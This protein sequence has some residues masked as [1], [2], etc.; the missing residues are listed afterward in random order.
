MGYDNH[1]I[2]LWDLATQQVRAT[3]LQT[4]G[5]V[6]AL[7][8]SANGRDM[9]CNDGE[10]IRIWDIVSQ[11]EEL[12]LGTQRYAFMLASQPPLYVPPQGLPSL[13]SRQREGVPLSLEILRNGTPLRIEA[14]LPPGGPLQLVATREGQQLSLQVN[15]DPVLH[16]HDAMAVDVRFPGVL[17][18]DWPYEVRLKRLK[19]SIKTGAEVSIPLEQGDQLLAEG[20][21]DLA[22]QQFESQIQQSMVSADTPAIHLEAR[23]KAALCLQKLNRI[24]Q[25]IEQFQAV[26]N[27][28]LSNREDPAQRSWQLLAAA[29]LW[30]LYV[31]QDQ[32][33]PAATFLNE[34]RSR[35]RLPEI[36]RSSL[37]TRQQLFDAYVHAGKSAKL[38][39]DTIGH[40]SMAIEV[41]KLFGAAEVSLREVKLHLASAYYDARMLNEAELAATELL[42]EIEFDSPGTLASQTL[43]AAFPVLLLKGRIL[44]AQRNFSAAQQLL[45]HWLYSTPGVIREG[46]ARLKYQLLLECARLAMA[47]DQPASAEPYLT[48][49]AQRNQDNQLPYQVHATHCLLSGLVAHAQEPQ[50]AA[51][52]AWF[53]RGTYDHWRE[54]VPES[55]EI[56]GSRRDGAI[57]NLALVS[58]CDEVSEEELD[59]LLK[60]VEVVG[61]QN[62]LGKV[63]FSSQM[64]NAERLK[65][66]LRTM[67]RS[68]RG[69]EMATQVALGLGPQQS[70]R[71]IYLVTATEAMHQSASISVE[72][73]ADAEIVWLAS[74]RLI[75]AYQSGEV[76][77]THAVRLAATWK[78]RVEF[79]GWKSVATDL[80]PPLRGPLAYV[81]GHRFSNVLGQPLQ[82]AEFFKTACANA[83][84]DSTL[85]AEA[86]RKLQELE[87]STPQSSG[88]PTQ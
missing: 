48:Q 57:E 5:R 77:M 4:S 73:E 9:M 44:R 25:A 2:K 53:E 6:D 37:T 61:Q 36:A 21:A 64:V 47:Q 10:R 60:T 76:N 46:H 13:Q 87:A 79:P 81:L 34:I 84:A 58:L 70:A 69:R 3:L 19:A 11:R 23:Y 82:A 43:G 1:C 88:G 72:N 33:D 74:Q 83:A 52:Q 15:D 17:G 56:C 55:P 28:S 45:D 51:A 50:S 32:F 29:Q 24:E 68:P 39:S 54:S 18:L 75:D 63:V 80:A 31:V 71:A 59:R 67:W 30:L 49:F 7:A 38:Q 26:V 27:G 20:E 41:G 65:S 22:L 40:L 62:A 42:N 16:F 35:H 14:S 8:L 78:G 85:H 12:A 66:I 86:T